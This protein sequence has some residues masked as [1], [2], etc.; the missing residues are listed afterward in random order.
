MGK[1]QAGVG[2]AG[3]TAPLFMPPLFDHDDWPGSSRGQACPELPVKMV[4]RLS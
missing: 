1:A 2:S 4:I 3:L